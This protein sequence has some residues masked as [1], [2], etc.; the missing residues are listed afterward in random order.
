MWKAYEEDRLLFGDK[1]AG[2]KRSMIGKV[3]HWEK[4]TH[5]SEKKTNK[6]AP[7]L[8]ITISS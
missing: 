3:S 7:V 6:T 1:N 2:E 8:Y 5:W 4:W